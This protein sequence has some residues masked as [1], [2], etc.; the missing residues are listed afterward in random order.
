MQ[1]GKVN[2]KDNKE[3]EGMDK[4]TKTIIIGNI[5]F[6][7][8]AL[9]SVGVYLAT[10]NQHSK[11][12]ESNTIAITALEK[13][14]QDTDKDINKRAT[15]IQTASIERDNAIENNVTAIDG[16]LNRIEDKLDSCLTDLRDIKKIVL[17]PIAKNGM[18]GIELIVVSE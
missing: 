2:E 16:K 5:T 7:I 6:I 12:L 4:L 3:R 14:I 11:A 10:L 18:N 8:T 9:V 13:R 1:G 17:K 15:S